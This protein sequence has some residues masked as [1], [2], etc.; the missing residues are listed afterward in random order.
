MSSRTALLSSDRR[1][2]R[3]DLLAKNLG[4]LTRVGGQVHCVDRVA[5]DDRASSRIVEREDDGNQ[6]LKRHRQLQDPLA[7][8]AVVV[9]VTRHDVDR[10]ARFFRSHAREANGAGLHLANHA[11]HPRPGFREDDENLIRA[12]HVGRGVER[13]VT[14]VEVD[15]ENAPLAE[16]PADE[17][18]QKLH[19]AMR[20]GVARRTTEHQRSN[21]SVEHAA[22]VERQREGTLH[23][24]ELF[25][26]DHS[27]VADEVANRPAADPTH[28][29][30]V[31]RTGRRREIA[32]ALDA[33]SFL[34]DLRHARQE[35]AAHVVEEP[36][37]ESQTQEGNVT[38]EDV[39]KGEVRHFVFSIRFG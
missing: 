37:Q 36:E 18:A 33:I 8:V 17:T 32:A 5:D 22:V 1:L 21:A 19:D 25:L 11:V 14:I 3:D 6:P 15:S 34:E 27:D 29:L 35:L 24:V 7:R 12:H 39:R 9:H 10:L 16:E 31:F 30:V 20:S 28:L 2:E 38:Q 26:P 4:R 13:G 23:G